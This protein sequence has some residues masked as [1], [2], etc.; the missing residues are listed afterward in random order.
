M[1]PLEDLDRPFEYAWRP[2]GHLLGVKNSEP[3][4][5]AHETMIPEVV[6]LSLKLQQS[7]P[8]YQGFKDLKE[9]DEGRALSEGQVRV[10]EEKIRDAEH[11]GVGLEGEAKER[12]IEIATEL[13]SVRRA[14]KE[15]ALSAYAGT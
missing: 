12:F 5:I 9:G 15:R 8:I 10:L 1:K 11:S 14:V 2:V 7:R 13:T 4:R 6:A 3:L